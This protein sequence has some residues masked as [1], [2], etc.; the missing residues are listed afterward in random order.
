MSVFQTLLSRIPARFTSEDLGSRFMRGGAI[1]TAAVGLERLLRLVRSI[2]L[3]KLISSADI[4]LV[5]LVAVVLTVFETAGE[6]GIRLSVIQNKQGDTPAF[7]NASWW[8]QSIRGL[9][10][11]AVGIV[12][13][14]L[15]SSWM[16]KPELTSLLQA[17]FL[18]VAF[19][20]L[21]SPAA[22]LL[23]KHMR[24]G[25][26]VLLNQGTM[27]FGTVLTITLA[28]WMRNAWP[29]I[30][31]I[32][33]E[34]AIRLVLSFLMC[35]FKPRFSIDRGALRE[36][37]HFARGLAGMPLLILGALY[38]DMLVVGRMLTAQQVGYYGMAAL[39]ARIP[40]DLAMQIVG[41]LLLPAFSAHQDN[42][43]A[44]SRG[45]MLASRWMTL[46]AGPLAAF[47]ILWA[48][49]LLTLAFQPEY[50][51]AAGA[52]A[53]LAGVVFLRVHGVI[54]W[55]YYVATAQLKQNRLFT[56]VRFGLLA[57]LIVPMTDRFGMAGAAAAVLVGELTGFILQVFM[58]SFRIPKAGVGYVQNLLPG[59]LLGGLLASAGGILLNMTNL[60]MTSQFAAGISL[61]LIVYS[62]AAG[63]EYVRHRR[64]VSTV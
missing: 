11:T 61:L 29:M 16:Q 44:L 54:M 22:F 3:A 35:P 60:S 30:I 5:T 7:L 62:V 17:A 58:L 27:L 40:R 53:I 19:N 4:G 50:A 9:L 13:A 23:E 1:L 46:A 43:D 31:G 45:L 26:Y 52:L 36:L 41:K 34:G 49:P 51:A 14:G 63:W 64:K 12:T 57:V 20:A 33:A 39:L 59:L 56:M 18:A 38:A 32:A 42:P 48:K 24:F 37:F 10:L 55:N 28:V 25:K 6:A 2:V 21:I 47:F 15:I 8:F